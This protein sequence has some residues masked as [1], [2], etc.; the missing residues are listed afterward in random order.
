[1]LYYFCSYFLDKTALF[2]NVLPPSDMDTIFLSS[3][4]TENKFREELRWILNLFWFSLATKFL[5]DNI[6][7]D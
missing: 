5:L 6:D 3:N 2:A 7:K 4:L 1:M